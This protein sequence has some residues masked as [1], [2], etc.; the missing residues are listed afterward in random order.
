MVMSGG[1]EAIQMSN[2]IRTTGHEEREKQLKG[3]FVFNTKL[4]LMKR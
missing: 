1:D 3:D 4:R 2:E